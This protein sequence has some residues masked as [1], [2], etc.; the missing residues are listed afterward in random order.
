[1]A[2]VAEDDGFE[3]NRNESRNTL[4]MRFIDSGVEMLL[5]N[6]G[7]KNEKEDSQVSCCTSGYL[8]VTF[9]IL[10]EGRRMSLGSKDFNFHVSHTEFVLPLRFTS[11]EV[12]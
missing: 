12:K 9:P 7:D 10:E 1:M 4:Q 5:G 11:A 3:R 6:K 8:V 2:Q